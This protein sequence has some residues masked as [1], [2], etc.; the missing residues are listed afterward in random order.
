VTQFV[1]LC[2]EDEDELYQEVR[3]WLGEHTT[4]FY[5]R[6]RDRFGLSV[7][8]PAHEPMMMLHRHDV[9]VI[10]DNETE[11][12]AFKLRFS[13]ELEKK[14]SLLDLSYWQAAVGNSMGFQ[15]TNAVASTLTVS[16]LEAM[17]KKWDADY[18]G[19][20]SNL[21]NPLQYAAGKID[22]EVVQKPRWF[23]Y[24]IKITGRNAI[25]GGSST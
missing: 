16:H 15:S 6:Q 3:S 21:Y 23:G 4:Q 14:A 8:S 5:L 10:I 1:L 12:V 13:E 9:E 25:I 24:D 22:H 18:A 19:V 2:G 7:C 20:S 11:A 17:Q